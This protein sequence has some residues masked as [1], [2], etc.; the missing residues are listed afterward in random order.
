M[1]SGTTVVEH[2]GRSQT[3]LEWAKEFGLDRRTLVNRL[4]RG[5]TVA[6][7]LTEDVGDVERST[8][9]R[10]KTIGALM[11][12]LYKI[13]NEP[14]DD[15]CT[16]IEKELREYVDGNGLINTYRHLSAYF[17]K[18][19]TVE[20]DGDSRPNGGIQMAIMFGGPEHSPVLIDT[21]GSVAGS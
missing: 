13:S 5:Y 16:R 9:I 17:P 12:A 4:E 14:T 1:I 11:Q 3:V 15:G 21:R 7:A 10:T 18:T 8:G 20:L 19:Q 2:E 6:Q